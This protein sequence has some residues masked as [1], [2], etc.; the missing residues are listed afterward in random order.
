[1]DRTQI[2]ILTT[3]VIALV[4][5]S[6]AAKAS[7]SKEKIYGG[8][9]AKFFHYI[10]VVAYLGVL[11]AAL[12]GSLLVGPFKLGIPLALIYLLAALV[13]LLLYAVGERKARAGIQIE[14]QGW[15]EQDARSS[16]L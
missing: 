1:M 15:T 2:I 12:L 7:I 8:T 10:G 5:S 11:P 9:I 6:R 3:L 4:F 13:A 16:G 14:D